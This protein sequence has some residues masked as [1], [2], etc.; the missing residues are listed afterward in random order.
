M[1]VRRLQHIQNHLP[2]QV[3][4]R[5][6]GWKAS[7]LPAETPPLN[8]LLAGL[9][10]GRSV[11][12]IRSFT[13]WATVGLGVLTLASLVVWETSAHGIGNIGL[14]GS[15]LL[16][17][18]G[19]VPFALLQRNDRER[20]RA[21]MQLTGYDD[22]RAIAPLTEGLFAR[23]RRLRN[24]SHITLIRLL[25]QLTALDGELLPSLPRKRLYRC[26]TS[27]NARHNPDLA[28]AVQKGLQHIGDSHT[29]VVTSFTSNIIHH[30]NPDT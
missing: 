12:Q 11:Y 16:L 7:R 22:L 28:C 30:S 2:A 20:R 9:R 17:C 6:K 10:T 19:I 14:V 3:T 5:R 18:A 8:A 1:D 21:L 4:S 13:S 26:L 29:L 23:D 25:P 27:R 24:A 15:G